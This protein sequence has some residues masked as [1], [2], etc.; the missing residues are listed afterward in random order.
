MLLMVSHCRF[1][2]YATEFL[3]FFFF[4]LNPCEKSF[5]SRVYGFDICSVSIQ[6]PLNANGNWKGNSFTMPFSYKL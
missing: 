3:G 1:Y 5:K 6:A 4:F 2:V